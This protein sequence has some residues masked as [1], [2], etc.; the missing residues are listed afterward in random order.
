MTLLYLL[1]T[2][3]AAAIPGDVKK[4]EDIHPGEIKSGE[5]TKMS[6]ESSIDSEFSWLISSRYLLLLILVALL[7]LF[8]LLPRSGRIVVVVLAVALPLLGAILYGLWVWPPGWS[9]GRG[10]VE[11]EEVRGRGQVG[12]EEIRGRGHVEQEEVRGRGQVEQLEVRQ[13]QVV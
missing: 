4:A 2:T 12:Q 5:D 13:V 9:R 11:Q 10:Q 8:L 7:L 6:S 1:S 3:I